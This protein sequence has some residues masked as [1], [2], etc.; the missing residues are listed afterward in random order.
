LG[1]WKWDEKVNSTV[2]A[3]EKYG[4]NAKYET[5]GY[6]YASTDGNVILQDNGNWSYA[7]NQNIDPSCPTCDLNNNGS[8]WLD[9]FKAGIN[10]YKPLLKVSEISLEISASLLF[11]EV[12]AGT[13]FALKGI[14][15]GVGLSDDVAKTFQFGKYS[16]ITLDKPMLVSRYYDN[17]NAFAKGRFMTNSTSNSTFLDRMGMG[18]RT[19]W[20]SMTKVANWEIPAGSTIY[21]GRAAMQFPWLGGKTQYFIPEIG[22]INRVLIR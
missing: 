15:K 3:Q 13:S 16:E 17:V 6:S 7:T 10:A 1:T 21:Q 4:N 9:Q 19:S 8:L 22:N 5:P 11:G 18:I 20:N 14:Q 2:E 12:T